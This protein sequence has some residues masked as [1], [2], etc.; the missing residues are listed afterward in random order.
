MLIFY[1]SIYQKGS[2]KASTPSRDGVAFELFFFAFSEQIPFNLIFFFA[3][4]KIKHQLR[5]GLS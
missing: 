3:V 5:P 4:A 1:I 2:E